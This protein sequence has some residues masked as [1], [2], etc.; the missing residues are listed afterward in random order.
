[1][2]F[3]RIKLLWT[4]NFISTWILFFVIALAPLPFGSTDRTVIAFWCVLLSVAVILLS[5]KGLVR[6]ELW[7]IAG[8]LVIVAGYGFV[9]HEQLAERPWVAPFHPVWKRASEVLGEPLVPSA[10]IV[11]NGPF[12]AIGATLANMLSLLLGL[13]IGTD[14]VRGRQIMLVIATSGAIY[15]LYGVLSFLIE[16]GMLLWR[17][18]KFY[19][20]SVTGTFVNRNSAAAYFGSCAILWLLLLL[21][22]VRRRMPRRIVWR[23]VIR[24]LPRFSKREILPPCSALLIC[25]MALM[26]TVS[27]A[28]VALSLLAMIIA[29]TIFLK[30]DLPSRTG[31]WI[32][33]GAGAAL[34]LVLLQLFGGRVSSRFDSQGLDDEGRIEG[35]KSTLQIIA[36]N[37]WFGTGLGSFPQAFPPYRSPL[38]SISGIWERAHSTPLELAA[39]VGLPLACLVAAGWGTMQVILLLGCVGRRRS[40]MVVPLAA[41]AISTLALLHSSIDFTLQIPGYSIPFF[42][43]FGAGVA[44]A[45]RSGAVNREVAGPDG[46]QRWSRRLASQNPGEPDT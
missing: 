26:M 23:R 2:A 3:D 41:L 8:L 13:V 25:M 37:P 27:R 15:A 32:S 34:A 33:V 43:L 4:R 29:F 19:T 30:K 28:G 44:Q 1:M 14:R 31:I 35:W 39:D 24:D 18:K 17:D 11:R 46:L 5:T 42:G 7:V 20:S 12:F 10:S 22:K 9:L 38:I 36:D 6:G 21:H 40:S 45:L 16:P